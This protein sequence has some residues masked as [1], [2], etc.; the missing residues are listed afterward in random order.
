MNCDIDFVAKKEMLHPSCYRLN[1]FLFLENKALTNVICYVQY[2]YST[3]TN[4]TAPCSEVDAM[5][6]ESNNPVSASSNNENVNNMKE[7]GDDRWVSDS[8]DDSPSVDITVADNDSFIKSVTV[9]NT[10]NV[11]SITITVYDEEGNEVSPEL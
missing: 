8:T 10:T 9:Q 4:I 5:S 6:P 3:L 11:E 7:E 2:L 1:I